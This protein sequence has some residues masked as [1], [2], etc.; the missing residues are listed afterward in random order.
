MNEQW[1]PYE[2]SELIRHGKVLTLEMEM[3]PYPDHRTRTIRVWL[4]EE[5]DGETR[6][7]VIYLHDGQSVFASSPERLGLEADRVVTELKPEGISAIIVAIDT[8]RTRGSEL[9]PPYPLQ[10][11]ERTM[12]GVPIPLVLEE[13]TTELYARFM[14]EHLKP[15]ID[16]EFRTLSDPLNT[17][18]GGCSAGG[19]ASYYLFLHHPDVFG[20]AMCYSPGFPLFERDALFDELEAYDYSRLTGHRICF[21]NGDQ[22]IDATSIYVV[23]DIYRKLR[24]KG[25]D[26]TQNMALFDT[27]QSHYDRAWH[28]YLPEMLRFLFLEDNKAELPPPMPPRPQP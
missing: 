2:H 11:G 16:R 27:R 9:T 4:P 23:L 19:S 20:K 3:K 26:A 15:L 24:E 22:A 5:Y 25:L 10:K 1:K 28:K 13:S 17:C 18:V 14:I 7:P 6:F 8:A 12:N 21:Y